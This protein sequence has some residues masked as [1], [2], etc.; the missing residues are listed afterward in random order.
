MKAILGNVGWITGNIEIKVKVG[1]LA[2]IP[3]T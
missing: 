1:W 3:V 2:W